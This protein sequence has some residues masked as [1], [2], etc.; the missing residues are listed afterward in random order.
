MK[1]TVKIFM[2]FI[3]IVTM[4]T[5]TSCKKI[6]GINMKKDIYAQ[7]VL[8]TGEKINLQLYREIAPETVDNFVKLATDGY[9]KGAIFH[10]VIEN[11]MIQTGGYKIVEDSLENLPEIDSIKGE[12]ASNGYDKND[13]KHELGV[14]SMA[15]SS[16]K[17]SATGQF[18]ICSATS[19][20]LDGEYAAFGKTTDEASNEVVLK[21]SR[22]ETYAPHYYFQNF[23]CD[24][25]EIENVYISNEIFK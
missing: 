17:N 12:F 22:V 24:I 23:P 20:H 18:F 2:L 14:I 1:K 13:L 16:D 15:R 10:R 7:I 8:T 21:I 25:I 4:F 3:V 19:T 11:F 6:G 9:Y 5:M